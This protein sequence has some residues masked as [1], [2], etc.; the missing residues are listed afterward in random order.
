MSCGHVYSSNLR[1]TATAH[2]LGRGYGCL[3]WVRI[4]VKVLPSRL[5][6]CVQYRFILHRDISRVYSTGSDDVFMHT[7]I[8]RDHYLI[9]YWTIFITSYGV[10]NAKNTRLEF[11]RNS[12]CFVQFSLLVLNSGYMAYQ[13]PLFAIMG[14]GTIDLF[15]INKQRTITQS[16]S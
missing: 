4:L 3:L 16:Y 12:F 10:N 15:G 2:A 11:C 13:N 1:K 7:G 5:L 8:K 9:Q 6:S 14:Y